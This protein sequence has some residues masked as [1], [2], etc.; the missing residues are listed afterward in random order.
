LPA[1]IGTGSRSPRAKIVRT[2]T[3][4]RLAAF[5]LGLAL[6]TSFASVGGPAD[7]ATHKKS[8]TTTTLP[9]PSVSS[10]SGTIA[11]VNPGISMEVQNP[12]SGQV[13]VTW[14][15]ST[16]FTQ[17]VTFPS[18]DLAVGDCVTATSIA[19]SSKTAKS[20]STHFAATVV[21]LT[22]PSSTGSCTGG[23]GFGGAGGAGGFGGLRPTGGSFSRGTSPGG[24]FPRGSFPGGGT[25]RPSAFS[26]AFGKITS[27]SGSTIVVK[28]TVPVLPTKSSKG[29]TT[30]T[31][32][33]GSTPHLKTT[34]RISKVTFTSS[35]SFT[36]SVT[37]ASSAVVV[38]QCAT[39]LGPADQTGAITAASVTIRAPASSGCVTSA[40]GGFG[41]GF[42][43]AAG[44]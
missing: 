14:T 13:T 37:A 23:G 7:A 36:K 44:G 25:A 30:T 40:F 10:A 9:R 35:T 15:A 17:T 21:S 28:G 24:S 6:A 32:K 20:S 22:Q 11:A 29:S 31:V 39:A 27:I 8:T 2:A 41:R 38:G 26:S 12:T 34:T 19:S 42:G 5:G 1:L 18:S 33:P 4:S 43:G 3:R 16:H